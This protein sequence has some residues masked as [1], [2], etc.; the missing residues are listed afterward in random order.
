MTVSITAVWCSFACGEKGGEASYSGCCHLIV[1]CE[2]NRAACCPSHLLQHWIRLEM[3][4]DMVINRLCMRIDPGD[5]SYTPSLV[6]LS[7]GESI[8]TLKEM[9]TIHIPAN[10]T[11]VTL[12]SDMSEVGRPLRSYPENPA[13]VILTKRWLLVRGLFVWEYDGG[14]AI[15]IKIKS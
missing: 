3:Q 7:A 1:A 2:C 6:V 13:K 12:I 9:R 14:K 11:L 4:P 10:E 15:E 8:S 5:S